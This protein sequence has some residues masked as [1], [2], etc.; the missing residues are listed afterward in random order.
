MMDAY[1]VH[2]GEP[3]DMYELHDIARGTNSTYGKC[4]RL[5]TE[6]GCGFFT[7][8]W[9]GDEEIKPCTHEPCEPEKFR[10]GV[11]AI[12]EMLGD[13]SDGAISQIEDFRAMGL[14]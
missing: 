12:Y 6:Y 3:W 2:C 7:A 10:E 14:I 9:D 8:A 4:Y 11:K 13:D 1:C 5:F